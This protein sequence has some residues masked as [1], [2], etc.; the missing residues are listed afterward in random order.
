MIPIALAVLIGTVCL[1]L[2][3]S[4]PSPWLRGLLPVLVILLA[5]KPRTRIVAACLAGFLWAAGHADHR[6]AA[7]LPADL[8]GRD[9]QVR[10]AVVSLPEIDD[11]ATRFLFQI[12]T[13]RSATQW[14]ASPRTVRLSWYDAPPLHAGQGW[15]FTVRLKRRHGFQNPGGFDY[16]G[17]LSQNGVAATGYV[18]NGEDARPS[19]AADADDVFLRLRNTVDQRLRTALLDVPHSG[20]LR[21]LTLGLDDGIPAAQWDVFRTTGT[22]HLVAISGMHI[23]L[24]AG[25]GFAGMRWLW[26]R[27]AS[28]TCRLAAPRAA[29]IAAMLL[30]TLYSVLAGFGIPTRRAWIMVLVLLSGVLLGRPTRPGHSLALALLAVLLFDPFAVLSP[31]FWLSFV[32]VAIIFARL[33]PRRVVGRGFTAR[34]RGESHELLRLQWALSL[35]LLPLTLLFF[36]QLGWV[37]PLANLLAVP[38]T[39]LLLMPLVF[40]GL[41]VLYPLPALAHALFAAAGWA[42]TRMD[43]LLGVL[44]GLPG[45]RLGMPVVPLW[46]SLMA[47]TGVALL[48]MPRGTPRRAL[49]WFMVLPLAVWSPP[50]PGT[51]AVWFTLLDVGQGLAAVVRTREH[52]LVYDAGPRFSADFDAGEAVVVPFLAAQG[53]RQVDTLIVSHGDNDHRGGAASLDA[54][55]PAFHVL[56][57]VPRFIDWRYAKRCVAGQDW[58]WDGVRFRMLHPRADSSMDEND[59]SCVLQVETVNGERLLLPGDIEAAAEREL[60]ARYGAAL[61][62]DIV[63]APHHGSRT[64]STAAFIRAVAPRAVLIPAGHRNRY[65]FPH[66]TV[67]ARYRGFGARLWRTGASG[68]LH[69]RLGEAAAGSPEGERQRTRR[70]WHIP[71]AVPPER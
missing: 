23:S 25:L 5:W 8:E 29:A 31:G 49:G 14:L 67:T 55:L 69:I 60:V 62:S 3:P 6:L 12:Q 68:A 26:S 9:L 15:R 61:R 21:A 43:E 4:L 7:D 28:L 2:L 45:T 20:L 38:W 50:R 33:I 1:Q 32:A 44:A 27:G 66:P 35:G 19:P 56:T 59:N 34:L 18:R 51:G 22:G 30:A 64:S 41:F 16:E 70:Y 10:G 48:L 54:R 24:V 36:G 47:C 42:A 40:A 11:R 17:W 37:A 63:V 39:T 57:S 46:V 53:I 65:G 52:T 58:T 13:S 71:M